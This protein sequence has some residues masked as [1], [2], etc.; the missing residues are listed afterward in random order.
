[1]LPT[2]TRSKYF[3]FGKKGEIL[4]SAPSWP[5]QT[6]S[7][8]NTVPPCRIV[9]IIIRR[10][11]QFDR[12]KE[13]VRWRR[14]RVFSRFTVFRS[15]PSESASTQ[16]VVF[17]GVCENLLN[18]ALSALSAP[19][20]W[21][22]FFQIIIS[23]PIPFSIELLLLLKGSLTPNFPPPLYPRNQSLK[24]DVELT[25]RS[26]EIER[27]NHFQTPADSQIR[28]TSPSMRSR[29]LKIVWRRINGA[30]DT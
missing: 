16:R 10:K 17:C 8:E 2:W 19:P 12:P 26:P 4:S 25:P 3:I 27:K 18:N 22:I 11:K 6:R 21:H 9:V 15:P 29:F 5:S 1:M 24:L 28:R 30:V 20:Q 14:V 23:G 13:F 7:Y